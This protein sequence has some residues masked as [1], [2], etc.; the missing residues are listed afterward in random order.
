MLKL[1]GKICSLRMIDFVTNSETCHEHAWKDG[2]IPWKQ[3]VDKR[4]QKEW[5]NLKNMNRSAGFK[6]GKKLNFRQ[7]KGRN[8]SRGQQ[9]CYMKTPSA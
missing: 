7:L 9:L 6:I 4:K 5:Q 2:T 3:G 1:K 8:A